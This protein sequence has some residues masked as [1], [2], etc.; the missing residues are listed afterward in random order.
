[1][2]LTDYSETLYG[3]GEEDETFGEDI[4]NHFQRESTSFVTSNFNDL[5]FSNQLDEEKQNGFLKQKEA[6]KN[7]VYDVCDN[8]GQ[9]T[10]LLKKK[11]HKRKRSFGNVSIVEDSSK[12][13]G[14]LKGKGK[15][16]RFKET[17]LQ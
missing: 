11:H 7:V 2:S 1:M 6:S 13:E 8:T 4:S 9:M 3:S 10:C 16:Q 15:R 17:L 14:Q 5:Y 12:E